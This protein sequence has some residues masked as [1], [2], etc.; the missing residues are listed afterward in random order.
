MILNVFSLRALKYSQFQ[1][2]A[3]S[4]LTKCCRPSLAQTLHPGDVQ[5]A[6]WIP[7]TS[8]WLI[9]F[10]RT[11]AENW[12]TVPLNTMWLGQGLPLYQLPSGILNQ[13]ATW[14]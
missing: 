5:H 4:S 13:D 8:D 7:V 3:E 9:V 6:P 1:C 11:W 10:T 12:G 14:Y 2:V